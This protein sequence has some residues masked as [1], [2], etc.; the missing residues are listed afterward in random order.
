MKKQ[1]V[2]LATVAVLLGGCKKDNFIDGTPV[3]FKVNIERPMAK[4]HLGAGMKPNWDVNDSIHI[5]GVD[6]LVTPVMN[7]STRGEVT[8]TFPSNSAHA[9]YY[10]VYPAS[11]AK[12]HDL[13]NENQRTVTLPRVQ[14]YN[15]RNDVQVI[16]AP[17]SASILG[18]NPERNLDFKNLC[19]LLQIRITND[20]AWDMILDSVQVEASSKNIRGGVTI[21]GIDSGTPYMLAGDNSGNNVIS[22]ARKGNQSIGTFVKSSKWG[23]PGDDTSCVVYLYVPTIPNNARNAFTIRVFSHPVWDN[24]TNP[25]VHNDDPEVHIVYT[26]TQESDTMGYIGRS[27]LVNVNFSLKA[28]EPY[29]TTITSMKKFALQHT[30]NNNEQVETDVCISRGH[31]Q[32]NANEGWRFARRQWDFLQMTTISYSGWFEHFTF[33]AAK[34]PSHHW[35]LGLT[36]SDFTNNNSNLSGTS[37]FGYNFDKATG[38][39]TTWHTPTR[40]EYHDLESCTYGWCT[41]TDV[42]TVNNSTCS[43]YCCI[44]VPTALTSGTV[45]HHNYIR[46]FHNR[47]DAQSLGFSAGNAFKNDGTKQVT[48]NV[49]T[50]AQFEYYEAMGCI[51]VPC[52][53][54]FDGVNP[55]CK[56]RWDCSNPPVGI[57]LHRAETSYWTCEYH[58][59]QTILGDLLHLHNDGYIISFNAYQNS[60]EGTVNVPAPDN[61][62]SL[63]SECYRRFCVRLFCPYGTAY[64]YHP[65]QM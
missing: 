28:C 56:N 42:P 61:T 4:V 29:G 49:L 2:I 35:A 52:I 6:A 14:Y 13:T 59:G 37:D 62:G 60:K 27:E 47:A 65:D 57:E 23:T 18:E 41:L 43:L 11:I 50:I 44:F 15:V 48:D 5:N 16:D 63:D 39:H 36:N 64:Q 51:L 19:G 21:S 10:A 58:Q 26:R 8:A 30:G 22:L 9:P 55:D 53:G 34:N 12:G 31:I 17:M 1:L 3:T 20:K 40:Q 25:T 7:D 45:N 38:S 24:E 33:D 46:T 32:Y 54:V